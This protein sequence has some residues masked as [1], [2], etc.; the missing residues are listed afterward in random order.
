MEVRTTQTA[1][2]Q[3]VTPAMQ[4]A[5]TLGVKL[6]E[7][8]EFRAWAKASEAASADPTV[9]HLVRQIKA[10]DPAEA[11]LVEPNDHA[12]SIAKLE[13][14]LEDLDLM[15]EYRRAEGAARELLRVVDAAIGV[16]AGVEF[17]A[18]AKRSCCGG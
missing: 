13:T 11:S 10:Y 9:Q 15:K 5:R 14:E 8:A 16:A 12:A 18:N 3:R 7:T 6:S 4:R 1:P 17:A 2:A